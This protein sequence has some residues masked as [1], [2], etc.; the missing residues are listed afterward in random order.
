[1]LSILGA[2]ILLPPEALIDAAAI[3]T[4]AVA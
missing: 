3:R 1:V 4:L 2:V